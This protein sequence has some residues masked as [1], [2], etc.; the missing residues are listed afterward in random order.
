MRKSFI[1]KCFILLSL[2]AIFSCEDVIEIE[3][4]AEEPRLIIDA[5][6]RVDMN[7]TSTPVAIEVS[8]TDGFF[9][10][11]PLTKLD[12][13]IIIIEE[14]EDDLIVATSPIQFED[15]ANNF[16]IYNTVDPI[17]N[18]AFQENNRFSLYI[19]H[20]GAVYLAQTFFSPAPPIDSLSQGSN[21]LFD[22]EETEIIIS[23]KDIEDQD[24]FYVFDF[25]FGE[26]LT[27]EDQFYKDQEY[28]FSYFYEKELEPG[29]AI[30]V[31][32]LGA[33][34]RFYNYMDLLIEQSEGTFGIFETPVAT[35][36]GNFIDVTNLDNI[37]TFDNVAQP[38]VFALGYF[39]IVQEHKNRLTIE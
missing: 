34:R 15:I 5:L 3:I 36:R 38:D 24:N 37:D 26:Y 32:I 23:F 7:E 21:T 28:S 9:G 30:E 2:A 27:T 19:E 16:G 31:S 11:V 39:A 17:P 6:I 14:I 10:T 29:T 22:E 13:I 12:N 18:S 35:V 20:E 1:H 4:P 8:L 25:G 33:D